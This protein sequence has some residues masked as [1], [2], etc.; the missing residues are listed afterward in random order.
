MYNNIVKKYF[1]PNMTYHN[2]NLS[3]GINYFDEQN[4][5]VNV[6]IHFNKTHKEYR[7]N[8]SIEQFINYITHEDLFD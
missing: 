6:S 8:I 4:L 2:K 5:L 3:I 7:G 1:N